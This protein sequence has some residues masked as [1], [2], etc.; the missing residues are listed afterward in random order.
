M[1]I[2]DAINTIHANCKKIQMD[3][4]DKGKRKYHGYS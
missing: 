2:N 4:D 3:K 1:K